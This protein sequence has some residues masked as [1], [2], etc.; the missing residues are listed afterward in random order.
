MN[1]KS[2]NSIINENKGVVFVTY[3]NLEKLDFINHASSTR[4]GGV[5]KIS[6]LAQMNLRF[7]SEDTK[8]TVIQNYK[9]FADAI[10][11]DINNMVFSKQMH[12]DNIKIAAE[13]DRGKGI[14]NDLDYTNI[15][16]LIT[17][18]KNVALT[19]FGADCV[20]ILFAD[21]NKKAIGAAHC[22]W[23]GTYKELAGIMVEKFKELYMSNPEDIIVA[24]APCIHK[25]CYEVDKK[26]FEDF[27]NKFN[28]I[29]KTD[30]FVVKNEKFY[31]DLPDI[32]RQILLKSGIKSD[33]ILVSDLCT[34]CAPD[35]LFSHRKSNGKRGVMASVIEIIK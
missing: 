29:S 32:N 23:R 8:E 15:D 2:K 1:L 16:G 19:I 4:I 5:S 7:N 26:L 21:K 28:N 18:K 33:N 30:A 27:K 10:G 9:I 3:P 31:L 12:N 17:N 35:M 25:C 24:I 13:S 34:G 22:G 14:T 20:P 11:T 6:H